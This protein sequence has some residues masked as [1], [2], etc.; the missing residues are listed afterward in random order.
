MPF[1]KDSFDIHPQRSKRGYL[2]RTGYLEQFYP[3][4]F[5]SKVSLFRRR[6]ELE[7]AGFFR[8]ISGMTNPYGLGKRRIDA[9]V[10]AG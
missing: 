6:T 3:L 4:D 10:A 7:Y 2:C 5:L 1:K 8:G 9:L